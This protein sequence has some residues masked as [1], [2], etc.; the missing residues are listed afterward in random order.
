MLQLINA[1]AQVNL[2][3]SAGQ[4][5]PAGFA[6]ARSA[7]GETPP[8]DLQMAVQAFTAAE[9][10]TPLDEDA[11]AVKFTLSE[12]DAE[13]WLASVLDQQTVRIE[14]REAPEQLPHP[15]GPEPLEQPVAL[16]AEFLSQAQLQPREQLPAQ[17][18]HSASAAALSQQALSSRV[19]APMPQMAAEIAIQTA[20]PAM[21]SEVIETNDLERLASVSTDA[22]K[23]IP[24][25]A[26]SSAATAT[27]L[28]AERPL[29]LHAPQTQWGEQMLASLR[30][31]VE[32]QIN[33]RIQ[34]ATI[35][36]DPPE[37]GSL[38]IFLSH[39]S[40]RL[41]VQLSAANADVARLL[42]QT[43]ERLRQEL[44]GQSFVQVNV[45]VSADAQG[46]RQQGQPR[47]VW[48]GEEPVQAA[49][50]TTPTRERGNPDS[51]SDVLVTV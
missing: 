42:Q 47:Q 28:T 2:S 22:D 45:Q 5:L 34:N 50:L 10:Q 9:R 43:S 39:E 24:G 15:D 46:G 18:S 35:R 14:A 29:K 7:G 6:Q 23:A 4:N 38:E 33:Q 41:S 31:H 25:T 51:T 40:G 13:Q 12:A 11:T 32:L 16:P 49:S 8:F 26:T 3:D 36:L 21:A 17:P 1:N 20:A 27:P 30:E 44:V 37:L 19:A 48:Q